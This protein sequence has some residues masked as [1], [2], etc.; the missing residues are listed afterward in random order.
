MSFNFFIGLYYLYTTTKHKFVVDIGLY[1]INS[2]FLT[3]CQIVV[4]TTTIRFAVSTCHFVVVT[5]QTVVAHCP[6]L[7]T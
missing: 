4:A 2:G 1:Q 3:T 7:F 5:C 6:D